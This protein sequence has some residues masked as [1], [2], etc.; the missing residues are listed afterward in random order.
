MVGAAARNKSRPEDELSTKERHEKG[1]ETIEKMIA[2][3]GR[4]IV[5]RRHRAVENSLFY[6]KADYKDNSRSVRLYWF[7]HGRAVCIARLFVKYPSRVEIA[8]FDDAFVRSM[9][10]DEH[11]YF[12]KGMG[13]YHEFVT[14]KSLTDV[15]APDFARCI[16]ALMETDRIFS[17][18]RRV[19]Q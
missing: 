15:N 11:V 4:K 1:Y 2:L 13:I 9:L 7:I 14:V 18:K 19:G 12:T 6:E 5:P 3:I 10:P 8:T 17:N 16:D